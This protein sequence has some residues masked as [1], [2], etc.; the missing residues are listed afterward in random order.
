MLME[1]CGGAGKKFDA[2]KNFDLSSFP[3]PEV[4]LCEHVKRVNY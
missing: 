3:P 2:K 4:C 1:K